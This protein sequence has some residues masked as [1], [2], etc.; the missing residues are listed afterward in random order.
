MPKIISFVLAFDF[1]PL[2]L[3]GYSSLPTIISYIFLVITTHI[4]SLSA[5]NQCF[6]LICSVATL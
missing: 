1:A 2:I 3:E 5:V 4:V 6:A